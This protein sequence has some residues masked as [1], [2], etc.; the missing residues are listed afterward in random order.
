MARHKLKD[1]GL[2]QKAMKKSKT[3]HDNALLYAKTG[4]I[5][6]VAHIPMS[7]VNRKDKGQKGSDGLS[8]DGPACSICGAA[9]RK[10]FTNHH[11]DYAN[12]VVIPLCKACHTWLHAQGMVFNHPFKRQFDR[13]TAPYVFAKRVVFEYERALTPQIIKFTQAEMKRNV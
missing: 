9:H 10:G 13:A 3:I 12:N 2:N 8:A 5:R 4:H 11:V 6:G 7:N 1:R